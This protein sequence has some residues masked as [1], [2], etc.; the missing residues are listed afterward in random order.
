MNLKFEKKEI[1]QLRVTIDLCCCIRDESFGPDAERFIF[2]FG[3]GMQYAQNYGSVE[4]SEKKTVISTDIFGGNRIYYFS[5]GRNVTITDNIFRYFSEE[6]LNNLTIDPNEK[7]YFN[8]HGYTSG[9]GTVYKEIKKTPP[10]SSLIIDTNGLMLKSNWNFQHIENIP[11]RDSFVKEVHESVLKELSVLRGVDRPV[12]LCFSGGVDSSYLEVVLQEL[13]IDHMLV[14]FKDAS[15]AANRKEIAKAREKA[16][17]FGKKLVEIDIRGKHDVKIEEELR[18]FNYFDR[19]YGRLHMYGVREISNRYKNAIIVNGQNSD[20]ILSF[21]PSEDKMSSYVKRYFIYGRNRILKSLYGNIIGALFRRKL[22]IPTDEERPHALF[23]NFKYCML[24]ENERPEYCQWRKEMVETIIEFNRVG[25]DMNQTFTCLK[26]YSHTHSAD[27]Q[28]VTQSA[29]MNGLD[30]LM[31][32]STPR[33][34]ELTLRYKQDE[35]ELA[36][37][38]Y[39][40]KDYLQCSPLAS[41]RR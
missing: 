3:D 32:L 22:R 7:H 37:P 24:L 27:A 41:D 1:G 15:V 14:F 4:I 13:N 5:D 25:S 20:S 8:K 28:I 40:L 29:K 9:F 31:P 18:K 23:D 19:H 26:L 12:V 33:F 39:V 36:N 35:I 11:D 17:S 34:I 38:K 10:C 30:L 21:G 6:E 16:Q 2:Q